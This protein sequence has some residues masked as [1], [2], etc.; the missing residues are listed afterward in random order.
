MSFRQ[1]LIE[2]GKNTIIS[3]AGTTE[4]S[5]SKLHLRKFDRQGLL[6]KMSDAVTAT[7][8]LNRKLAR[9]KQTDEKVELLSMQFQEISKMLMLLVSM[10]INK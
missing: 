6:N 9:T 3:E 2:V 8:K 10:Y 7:E 5:E 1:H 4:I